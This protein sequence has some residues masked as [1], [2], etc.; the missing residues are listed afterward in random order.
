MKFTKFIPLVCALALTVPAFAATNADSNVYDLVV[1]DYFNVTNEAMV[2]HGATVTIGDDMSSLT[3]TPAYGVTYK[4][5]T[6]AASKTFYVKATAV[7]ANTVKAFNDDCTVIAFA[8]D[9]VKPAD[10]AITEV[11]KASPTKANSANAIAFAFT[12]DTIVVDEGTAPTVTPTSQQ[13]VYT[14][15]PGTYHLPF[16]IGTTA[17]TD[18]FSSHDASGTYK[19]TITITDVAGL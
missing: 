15:G 17:R 19:A 16:S 13:L 11:L 14:A 18:T 6:N 2:N 1:P 8:N 4:V 3:Y 10:T 7:G 12:Q 5:V 9:T